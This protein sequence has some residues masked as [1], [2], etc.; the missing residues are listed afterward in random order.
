[1]PNPCAGVLIDPCWLVTD[2]DRTSPCEEIF[3]LDEAS[4][5]GG[6]CI[7]NGFILPTGLR[8]D[9]DLCIPKQGL[10]VADGSGEE[11]SLRADETDGRARWVD[12]KRWFTWNEGSSGVGPWRLY[13]LEGRSENPDVF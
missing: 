9:A 11:D 5:V 13:E 1:M 6:V 8:Q 4:R 7:W 3:L 2:V 12:F 10:L